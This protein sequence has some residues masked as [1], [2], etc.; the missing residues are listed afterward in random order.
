MKGYS[1][2]TA[3]YMRKRAFEYT[4]PEK[5]LDGFNEIFPEAEPYMIK[6]LTEKT[7]AAVS[8]IENNEE[9]IH[10]IIKGD[11]D[12]ILKL[13]EYI[14]KNF[15]LTPERYNL[16]YK[17][18]H[19]YI[20]C[21]INIVDCM[22][23]IQNTFPLWTNLKK[24]LLDERPGTS[25]KQWEYIESKTS[26]EP[27]LIE[28][29][30]KVS[31]YKQLSDNDTKDLV[32]YLVNFTIPNARFENTISQ[33]H[34]SK[35]WFPNGM[36]DP[37]K[38]H[39]VKNA[40][41][42][43]LAYSFGLSED[44][45]YK[46]CDGSTNFTN[47]PF[48]YE[49]IILKFG[50]K[51]N[52][53]YN[54]CAKKIKIVSDYIK[55]HKEEK[56]H[57]DVDTAIEELKIY[58]D[59]NSNTD[60]IDTKAEKLTEYLCKISFS[61]SLEKRKKDIASSLMNKLIE[62]TNIEKIQ[63]YYSMLYESVDD[64][65]IQKYPV[66]RAE[67]YNSILAKERVSIMLLKGNRKI[68]EK[69]DKIKERNEKIKAL[70]LMCDGKNAERSGLGARAFTSDKIEKLLDRNVDTVYRDDI[71]RICY[72]NAL[73]EYINGCI[74]DNNIN[75]YFENTVNRALENCFF[76]PLHLSLPLDAL[77]Y[78]ALS[79]EEK[80]KPEVYQAFIDRDM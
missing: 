2:G 76:H 5:I 36:D 33:P 49:A 30:K 42:Y 10:K 23:Y 74:T 12:N 55:D 18:I 40:V 79:F 17:L 29:V 60:D 73:I 53:P 41:L 1:T 47:D 4:E 52:I 57:Y 48:D 19:H 38:Q 66:R 64:I 62:K 43:K 20:L 11:F 13:K 14:N 35:G 39:Q 72:L 58:F 77:I 54:E 65:I 63:D 16:V 27:I 6:S 68:K 9:Q 67:Y 24:L 31:N 75:V 8:T 59:K 37:P 45:I 22:N 46:L 26:I 15:T 25:K 78:M 28:R 44:N 51:N 70:A 21:K 61:D 7:I 34:I 3:G 80:C 56:N 69:D 50:L 32:A 71:L